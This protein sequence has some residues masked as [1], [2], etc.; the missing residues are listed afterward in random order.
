MESA[1]ISTLASKI[2]SSLKAKNSGE[3]LISVE[4]HI[5]LKRE[6]DDNIAAILAIRHPAH[7]RFSAEITIDL[8]GEQGLGV[9]DHKLSRIVLGWGF[10][11]LPLPKDLLET[12][13][14]KILAGHC[15]LV[16][17]GTF[18]FLKRRLLLIE[19]KE[20]NSI[21][22][23]YGQNILAGLNIRSFRG[24]GERISFGSAWTE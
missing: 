23:Y 4:Q 6:Y 14:G 19:S 15:Y 2:I 22:S 11:P 7:T 13:V 10:E 20:Y 17:S 5:P 24:S 9:W 1:A 16:E 12:L 21:T 8:D 3:Y 18:T